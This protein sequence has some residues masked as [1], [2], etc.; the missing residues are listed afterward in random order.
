MGAGL[1]QE[2]FND[3]QPLGRSPTG[4]EGFTLSNTLGI[5]IAL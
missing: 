2:K 1:L 4:K 3:V 5:A